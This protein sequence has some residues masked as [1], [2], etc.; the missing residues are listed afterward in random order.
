MKVTI[1][2]LS[3]LLA[4][5]IFAIVCLANKFKLQKDI[6]KMCEQQIRELEADKI[7][8]QAKLAEEAPEQCLGHQGH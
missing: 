1:I 3:V 7:N 5:A 4:A 2:I 6:T 8:L